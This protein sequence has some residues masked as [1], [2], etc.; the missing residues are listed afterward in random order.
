M[1]IGL[2]GKAGSGKDTVF[3]RA[4]VMGERMGLT[5]P[6]RMAFADKLKQSVANL[7]DITV[8]QV[9]QLKLTGG[10]GAFTVLGKPMSMR[11]LLQRYGTEAHREVFGDNFWV[12]AL[13]PQGYW[14]DGHVIFV[15]DV[16]F[17]NEAQR[18]RQLG[19][20]VYR[21]QADSELDGAAAGHA[22][23]IVLPSELIDGVIDNTIRND[24]FTNLDKEV[25]RILSYFPTREEVG[26]PEPLSIID[27]RLG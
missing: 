27:Q 17:P 10:E 5:Q 22:S 19:G 11:V 15:T 1:L 16:R 9:E 13:L 24:G 14:H 23:E 20:Q 4:L 3:E 2:H 12:D 6:K 25:R 18:I 21:I 7:F 8:E 26:D